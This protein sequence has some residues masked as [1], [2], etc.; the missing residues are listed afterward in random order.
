MF[1]R[2]FPSFSFRRLLL[3]LVPVLFSLLLLVCGAVASLFCPGTVSTT[4]AANLAFSLFGLLFYVSRISQSMKQKSVPP[5]PLF[6]AIVYLPVMWMATQILANRLSVFDPVGMQTTND[7]VLAETDWYILLTMVVAPLCEELL[8]RG[9][10]FGWLKKQ[11]GRLPAYLCSMVFFA[12]M[13][14]TLPQKFLALFCGFLFA[15]VFDVSGKLWLSVVFHM[16]YNTISLLGGGMMQMPV[17]SMDVAAVVL[18]V[19]LCIGVPILLLLQRR[20]ERKKG[21]MAH[22]VSNGSEHS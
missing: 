17:W 4:V 11:V 16:I 8:F 2:R 13:H 10:W 1:R 9:I 18:T 20:A 12:L 22:A 21:G 3:C 14:A 19:L 7:A 5:V 6:G 15:Y